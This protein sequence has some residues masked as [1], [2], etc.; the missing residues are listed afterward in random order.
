MEH[1]ERSVIL[2]AHLIPKS[3]IR[4]QV[5]STICIGTKLTVRL[6]KYSWYEIAAFYDSGGDDLGDV[7]ISFSDRKDGRKEGAKS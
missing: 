6:K 1:A 3:M 7:R 2:S 5:F 4:G